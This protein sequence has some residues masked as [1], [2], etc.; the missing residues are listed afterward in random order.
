MIH[1]KGTDSAA[2]IRTSHITHT[3]ARLVVLLLASLQS[4]NYST[5]VVL[6]SMNKLSYKQ[7]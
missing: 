6:I 1:I 4:D 2:H 3:L 7:G 5:K